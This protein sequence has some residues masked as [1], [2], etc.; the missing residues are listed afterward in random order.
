M[1]KIILLIFFSF[2]IS[3]VSYSQLKTK[4]FKCDFLQ[5]KNGKTIATTLTFTLLNKKILYPSEIRARK[6]RNEGIIKDWVIVDVDSFLDIVTAE[7]SSS[8][9]KLFGFLDGEFDK[10]QGVVEIRDFSKE[11]IAIRNLEDGNINIFDK[12]NKGDALRATNCG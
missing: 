10:K 2:S 9:I 7:T 6:A 5:N 3:S 11:G 1:K 12:Y 4:E 8:Q